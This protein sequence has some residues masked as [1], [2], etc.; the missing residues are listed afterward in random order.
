MYIVIKPRNNKLYLFNLFFIL[1]SSLFT[2]LNISKMILFSL[3]IIFF[4]IDGKFANVETYP[5]ATQHVPNAVGYFACHLGLEGIQK[6]T[7]FYL[8]P[9]NKYEC[10]DRFVEIAFLFQYINKSK[11]ATFGFLTDGREGC[12]SQTQAQS[13]HCHKWRRFLLLLFNLNCFY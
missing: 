11:S 10:R 7:E 6:V 4:F 8:S 1:I 13:K 9:S 3:I 2:S 12:L 5:P